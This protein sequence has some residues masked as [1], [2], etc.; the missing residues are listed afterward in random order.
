LR[1][2][3]GVC[4]ES[5]D[6][7]TTYGN[8]VTQNGDVVTN[9][10]AVTN[11]IVI[12]N[13]VELYGI[14]YHDWKIYGNQDNQFDLSFDTRVSDTLWK[15][16]AKMRGNGGTSGYVNFTGVH[17]CV[18]S[19]SSQHLYDNKYIGYIVSSTK[20]YKSINSSVD[21]NNIGDNID[22]NAWDALPLVELAKEKDKKVFGVISKIDDNYPFREQSSG[23]IVSYFEKKQH[24]R[25]L[26]IAGVGEGCVWVCDFGNTIIEGGDYITS[27]P[28]S[29]IG[30]RQE[31]DLVHSYTVGKA[32]MNCDFDPKRIP[33]KMLSSTDNNT[34][35]DLLD[36]E[37]N[38]VY[39]DEYEI[40]YI[41]S[42]GRIT[43]KN[44][45]NTNPGEVFRMA[46]IGCTYTCS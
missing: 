33:V 42:D 38:I 17:H 24:D 45:Y 25:R 14:P 36:N 6:I 37:G 41:R 44:D 28:I 12:N 13:N 26:H 9:S 40:K 35:I 29:G 7:M 11:D 19:E 15:T 34:Y 4:V 1:H 22:K 5:G 20:K 21:I 39:E 8:I 27:S 31:D 2:R 10:C 43:D 23:N 30:M 32:T 16:S 46:F 3:S 18:A